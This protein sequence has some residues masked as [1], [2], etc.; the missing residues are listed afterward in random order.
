MLLCQLGARSKVLEKTH[1]ASVPGSVVSRMFAIW[2][3][4]VVL[5]HLPPP[6]FL[7]HRVPI[8]P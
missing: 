5:G 2:I 8:I 7:S 4:W 6:W 3:D 1:N